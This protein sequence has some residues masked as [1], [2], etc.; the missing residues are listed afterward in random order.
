M[1]IAG[2]PFLM[3]EK[4][5]GLRGFTGGWSQKAYE[6]VELVTPWNQQIAPEKWG[7]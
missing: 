5:A 1:W 7:G 3:A 4:S 6:L 2:P